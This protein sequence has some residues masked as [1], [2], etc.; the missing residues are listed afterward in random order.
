MESDG[1]FSMVAIRFFTSDKGLSAGGG[2]AGRLDDDL[3]LKNPDMS[4]VQLGARRSLVAS[5]P[6]TKKGVRTTNESV[7]A[8][9]AKKR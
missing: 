9:R 2:V 7:S 8:P 6:K 1:S 5:A 4:A 3:R